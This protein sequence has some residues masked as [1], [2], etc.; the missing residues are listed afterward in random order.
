MFFRSRRQEL[1]GMTLEG[2]LG[3]NTRLDDAAG[4]AVPLPRALVVLEDGRLLFSSGNDVLALAAWDGEPEAWARFDVPVTALGARGDLVAVGLADGGLAACD[5]TGRRLVGWATPTGL[6]SIS[7]C[8]VLSDDEVALVD[9][10]YRAD[11]TLLSLAAWA[12]AGRGMVVA[13]GRSGSRRELASGLNCP[14]GIAP[15]GKGSVIVSLLE[16][17]SVVE[18][19]GT[20]RQS[21]FP[22]Y[23][24]RIRATGSGYLICCLSRRDPL[25]E[26]LKTEKAFVAEMKAR[27]S[28]DH[29]LSPRAR[30]E[31]SHDFPIELGA[32]RLFGEVKP[33]APSFSYGLVI[34]TDHQ[35]VPTGSAHSRAN[36]TRHAIA[37]AVSWNGATVAVSMASGELLRFPGSEA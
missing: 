16:H 25:I 12:D 17:A 5:R 27:I 30:P 20:V 14:M 9:S 32:T 36:G 15:D 3:P 33:W 37:D 6:G 18:L 35:L 24:G 1:P 22:G 13:V 34:E 29:W 21:G 26:F 19:S 4:R 7:D 8:M 2:V 11:E 23:L 28:P 10:G 31:F